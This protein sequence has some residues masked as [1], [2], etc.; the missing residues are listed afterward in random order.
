MQVIKT[1]IREIH[2]A[3]SADAEVD[4]WVC[5]AYLIRI[6]FQ[7]LLQRNR[8]KIINYIRQTFGEMYN[9]DAGKET[10]LATPDTFQKEGNA[11]IEMK[12]GLITI[13]GTSGRQG[14][15]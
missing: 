1:S 2:A 12:N 14:R 5:A 9:L 4:L 8:L 7:L 13:T 3:G 10:I 11:E 15:D 6:C